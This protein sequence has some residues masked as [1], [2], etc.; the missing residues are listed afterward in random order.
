M[1]SLQRNPCALVIRSAAVATVLA[2]LSLYAATG[3]AAEEACKLEGVEQR[4]FLPKTAAPANLR[5]MAKPGEPLPDDCGFYKW[6][7]QAF[8]YE[9]QATGGQAAFLGQPTFEDVFKIKE[10]PLFADQRPNLLSLAPRSSKVSNKDES[11]HFRM[12]DLLQAGSQQV[13]VDPRGNVIWYAIHLNK[14]Y[15]AFVDDYGLT[16]RKTLDHMPVDL[17]FRT[18]SIELKSAW[19]IV[20]G[21]TPKNY[22]T[23]KALIPV[24]KTTS[25]GDIVKDGDKTRVVTVALLGIHVVGT[26]EGHPEF[27]WSTFEHVNRKKKDWV[28]DVA[29]DASANA[30]LSKEVLVEQKADA[31]TLYPSNPAHRVAAPVPG[32]NKG[33]GIFDLRL[34]AKTQTFTPRSPI[35]RQFPGSKSDDSHADD[36]ILSLNADMQARFEAEGG[37]DVRSN[38]QLVGAIWFNTPDDDFR[39]GVNFTDAAAKPRKQ[40]LFGGE[41]RLSSTTMESFTQS[42]DSFPN[43]F[44]CHNTESVSGVAASR[45]NVSHALS[46][47]YS[48]SFDK[49]KS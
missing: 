6:A 2:A 15:K 38:Y 16:D 1:T 43:C 26:I 4:A 27:V 31:Y 5:P 49:P 30:E 28:R 42:A 12:N 34:D 14:T 18:G 37:D 32:A 33:S 36:A 48:L 11:K 13:L 45:L 29:P 21:P 47:F 35:Y 7:W 23:T 41:D 17:T 25:T 10:S 24:F 40:P 8:L 9:T 19:Q 22:I 3:A 20:T 46:K 44:S 39:P